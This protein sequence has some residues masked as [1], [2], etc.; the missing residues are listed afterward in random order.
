MNAGAVLDALRDLSLRGKPSTVRDIA[1][2]M[3]L[4]PSQYADLLES[5]QELEARGQARFF[6]ARDTW[7]PI[8][9]SE[10]DEGKVLTVSELRSTLFGCID[11]LR[12]GR[13]EA[14]QAQAVANLSDQI[15]KSAMAEME[16]NRLAN[17]DGAKPMEM[18]T[19]R[20][21]GP[22]KVE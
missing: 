15:I 13:I 17:R 7:R 1:K 4:P 5:L 19:M 18:G 10:S 2:R 8:A 11:D 6:P 16:F 12:A 14:K 20:L 21:S 22:P 9:M 3:D